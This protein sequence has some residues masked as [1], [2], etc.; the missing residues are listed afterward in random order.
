MPRFNPHERLIDILVG[1]ELYTTADAAMREL[2]QNAVDAC[3]LFAS[4][5]DNYEPRID[6]RFSPMQN[7]V[8]V[9]DNGLGMNMEAIEDSFA[10]IGAPKEDVQHLRE[11]LQSEDTHQIA[12]FGIGILS[13]FGVADTI[14]LRSKM[15]DTPGLAFAIPD[16]HKPFVELDEQPDDKRGTAVKL[17]LKEGGPVSA[18]EAATA[19]QRF[20]RHAEHV[21]ITNVDTGEATVLPEEWVGAEE[22]HAVELSHIPGVRKG[23]LAFNPDWGKNEQPSE[24]HLIM[25]NGGFLVNTS[26]SDLL[27][28]EMVGY[29][30]EI[31]VEPGALRILMNRE[32]FKKDRAWEDLSE[33]VAISYERLVRNWVSAWGDDEDDTVD[34]DLVVHRAEVLAYGP[35]HT[36]INPDLVERIKRVLPRVLRVSLSGAGFKRS[37][38]EILEMAAE[39]GRV[40]YVREEHEKRPHQEDLA[41]ESGTLRVTETIETTLRVSHLL[42][43]GELVVKCRQRRYVER[44]GANNQVIQIHDATILTESANREGIRATSVDEATPDEVEL[45]SSPQGVLITKVLALDSPIKIAYLPGSSQSVIRDYSGRL[46]NAA[47]PEVAEVLRTLP[48]AFGNPIKRALLQVYMDLANLQFSDARE[49]ILNLLVD[50]EFDEKARLKGGEFHRE[51]LR[52]ELTTLLEPENGSEG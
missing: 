3:H 4:K 47:H 36:K 2:L 44:F 18:M 25:C 34:G 30:G 29:V 1:E 7:S 12:Q 8:E 49:R 27:P 22:P 46:L 20:A 6:V 37:L 15:E 51:F 19:A 17:I 26:V 9:V 43:K 48:D 28:H 23:W 16:Y 41:H 38:Q 35:P 14:E 13:C 39:Q 32:G 40:Y 21:H 33:A 5:E 45:V 42:A 50:A 11:L 10:A 31:D 52:Q 24:S